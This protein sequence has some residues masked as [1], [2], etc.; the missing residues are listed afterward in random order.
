MNAL[1]WGVL[2]FAIARK[3]KRKPSAVK[4]F[5]FFFSSSFSHRWSPKAGVR[6]FSGGDGGGGG[7]A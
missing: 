4:V 2:G 5:F 7:K 6:D 1:L 3:R